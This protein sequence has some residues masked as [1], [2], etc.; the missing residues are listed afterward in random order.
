[1][2][3]L[4]NLVQHIMSRE[5]SKEFIHSITVYCTRSREPGEEFIHSSIA[6]MVLRATKQIY[7]Q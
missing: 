6:H 5:P 7:T 2:K 1:M 3:S 4:F